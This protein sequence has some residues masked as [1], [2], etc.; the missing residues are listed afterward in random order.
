LHK[1]GQCS[2]SSDESDSLFVQSVPFAASVVEFP[3]AKT[4]EKQTTDGTDHADDE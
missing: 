4:P 3:R 2:V 1:R